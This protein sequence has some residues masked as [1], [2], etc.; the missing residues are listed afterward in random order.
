MTHTDRETERE[1]EKEREIIFSSTIDKLLL[2][3]LESTISILSMMH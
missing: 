3:E 2:A 1:K